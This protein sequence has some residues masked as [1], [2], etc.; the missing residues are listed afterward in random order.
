MHL[1][2]LTVVLYGRCA[3]SVKDKDGDTWTTTAGMFAVVWVCGIIADIG[4]LYG[5]EGC[6]Q[7]YIFLLNF[8]KR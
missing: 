1:L 6:T 8:F 5:S 4:E 2:H 3:N 7:V